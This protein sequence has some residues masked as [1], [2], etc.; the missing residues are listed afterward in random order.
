MLFLQGRNLEL[1]LWSKGGHEV[2]ARTILF[3]D[4]LYV[5]RTLDILT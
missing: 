5:H 1:P 4:V 2:I 3:S